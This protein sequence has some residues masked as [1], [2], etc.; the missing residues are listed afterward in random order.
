M[1]RMRFK[2]VEVFIYLG[3]LVTCDNYISREVK[4]R[5]VVASRTYYGLHS[6]QKYLNLQ[7]RT[8]LALYASL[9]RQDALYGHV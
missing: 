8:K 6:Q 2:V 3:T 5:V 7:K 4:R 9:I 1:D